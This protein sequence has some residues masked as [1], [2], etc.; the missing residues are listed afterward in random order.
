MAQHDYV[1]ANG[2]GS[3]VR[4]DLNNALS[5]I[6]SLNSGTSEPTDTFAYMLWADTTA[7]VLKIR[8]AANNAWITLR[9]LDGTLTI[10]G[11]SASTPGLYFAGDANT[12]I[13]SPGADQLAVST[14]GTGRFF[15]DASGNVGIGTSSPGYA[16]DV[17]SS[18][19]QVGAFADAF[20]QYKS[21]AGN[22]HVGA[23]S[24]NA[25]TFY[26]GTYGTGTERLR[27]DSSGN[28][29]IGTSS[30]E[31]PL[32]VVGSTDGDQLRV[33]QSGHY[34]RIGREGSGGHLEFYGSQSGYNGYIFSGANGERLRIDSSGNV[35]I[36]GQGDL[37]FNDSD[38]SNWVALQAPATVAS[39]VTWS[40][41]AADG[42]G[43]QV[44][45]TDGSGALGWATPL[46]QGSIITAATAVA[47]TSG[48]SID[49]TGIP[50]WVKRITVMFDGV[51]TDGASAY[52]V[53]IG[54][55]GGIETTGY[56]S[57]GNTL[58]NAGGTAGNSSTA[59]FLINNG[60]A[61]YLL[62][63][64]MT[65]VLLGSNTWVS[66]HTARVLT[67]NVQVGAG[68]KTLSDTL[69]QVRITT[70]NGTDTFDAGNINI[71]YEG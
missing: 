56:V 36:N 44:L 52:L 18:V 31:A 40:L 43:D 62:S 21:T 5:A 29:G 53:Q 34:Y 57:T 59:G 26:S 38:N 69:T 7:G 67:T 13:Y 58:N 23:S 11:G 17:A 51:S 9:E 12:G 60:S 49:F 30:P 16:L 35:I 47:S 66:S 3:A 10:E 48:T 14:G 8:N 1:I 28:V 65:I 39:N 45:K 55:S 15:V 68:T 37:R 25:Y 2:S 19:A 70:A 24:S 20:I 46:A 64:I 50:S 6:V 42:S 27:I 4:S 33:K 61:T 54:D 22:W 71:M 32:E 63:G 41:P